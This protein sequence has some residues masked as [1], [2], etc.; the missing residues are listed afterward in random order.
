[1]SSFNWVDLDELGGGGF[2]KVFKTRKEFD[3]NNDIFAKKVLI[4]IDNEGIKRFQKEVRLLEKLNHPRIVKVI[5]YQL[6]KDPYFFVMNKYKGS[7]FDEYPELTGDLNR[8][9]EIFNSIFE[10]VQYLHEQGIYHRDLKPEN[11]L[12]NSDSDIVISDFG[13]GLNINSNTTRLTQTGRGMGTGLY[14]AP[15]Q[16]DDSKYVD[17]RADLYSLGRMLYES[18]VGLLRNPITDTSIIQNSALARFI[19]RATKYNPDDRYQKIADLRDAFNLVVDNMI[20]GT[21]KGNLSVILTDI[22]SI[23]TEDIKENQLEQLIE[24][25][26]NEFNNPDVINDFMMKVTPSTF[27]LLENYDNGF[28]RKLIEIFVTHLTSQGWSFNFTDSI[29]RQ[30]RNLFINSNDS[31]IKAKLLYALL[32]V[33]VSHN[34]WYVMGLFRDLF[35][36]INDPVEALEVVDVLTP[37]KGSLTSIDI[38]VSKLNDVLKK[39]L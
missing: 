5:D 15:E 9:K 22:F 20:Y 33:G 35:Y 1:M 30:C 32:E 14:M 24:A 27:A 19:E 25:L 26:A 7:L 31:L 28:A 38:E 23:E 37:I 10:G 11:I 8:I 2:A 29:G 3:D 18:F 13:L 16:F 21:I 6:N 34:R 36:S 39:L 4:V 12:M 17:E